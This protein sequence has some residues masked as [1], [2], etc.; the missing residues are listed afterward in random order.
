MES[1]RPEPEPAWARGLL[2][3]APD[4]VR[5][6]EARLGLRFHNQD[7]PVQALLHRSA[8]LEQ[9]RAGRTLDWIASNERLEFLG[10]AVL[11]ALAAH[12]VYEWFPL[13]DEG[14]LTE[15]RSA[16]VRRTTFALLADD[17]GLGD[18]VYMATAERR[19]AG[20]GRATVLAEALEA[21]IGAVYLDH[22]W[23]AAQRLARGML[24]GRIEGLLAAMGE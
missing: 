2:I 24:S 14:V 9:E 1:E 19:A 11:N 21:V 6:L 4:R 20:R 17:L 15:A 18:L 3:D 13:A 8:V 5:G 22:G 12:L 16:L 23:E 10:D 7:L